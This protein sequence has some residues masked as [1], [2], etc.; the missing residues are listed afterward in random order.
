MKV[1]IAVTVSFVL[2]TRISRR[3]ETLDSLHGLDDIGIF[4]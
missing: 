4:P 1:R 2:S 3:V